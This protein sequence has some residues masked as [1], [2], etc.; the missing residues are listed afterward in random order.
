MQGNT[1][2]VD[3]DTYVVI[4]VTAILRE[5]GVK[6]VM[7]VVEKDLKARPESLVERRANCKYISISIGGAE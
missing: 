1:R 7:G 4:S 6:R 2:Y 3:I 5:E